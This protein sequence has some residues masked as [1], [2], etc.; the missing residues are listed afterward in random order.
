MSHVHVT[1][2]NVEMKYSFLG[3]RFAAFHT[4][5]MLMLTFTLT[6]KVGDQAREKGEIIQIVKSVNS[7]PTFQHQ[8]I[9]CY[10][11]KKVFAT[12]PFSAPHC[13]YLNFTAWTL[14]FHW[15]WQSCD[16]NLKTQII[17][18]PFL[19]RLFEFWFHNLH[20]SALLP[21]MTKEQKSSETRKTIFIHL[22]L[23]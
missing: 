10:Y 8:R 7:H 13:N 2:T 9:L 14:W 23:T 6:G 11:L 12:L 17:F 20:I 15:H 3:P 22:S 4:I 5:S 16:C 18:P 21:R 1:N 19:L